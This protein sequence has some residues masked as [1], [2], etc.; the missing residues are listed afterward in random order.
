MGGMGS[1]VPHMQDLF[2]QVP[3]HL[4]GSP[5]NLMPVIHNV[6]PPSNVSKISTMYES[7]IYTKLDD[8]SGLAPSWARAVK[9]PIPESHEAQASKAKKMANSRMTVKEFLASKDMNGCK[10]RQVLDLIQEKNMQEVDHRF[11]WKPAYIDLV[12]RTVSKPR[13]RTSET[14]TVSME[15][16]VKRIPKV[17]QFT[18]G[19]LG[20]ARLHQPLGAGVVDVSGFGH[21]QGHHGIGAMYPGPRSSYG[22][23]QGQPMIEIA[24]GPRHSEHLGPQH[25]DQGYLPM[26]MPPP[27]PPPPPH[28]GPR[29]AGPPAMV[30]VMHDHHDAHGQHPMDHQ[31]MKPGK[32]YHGEPGQ[33]GGFDDHHGGHSSSLKKK[34][35]LRKIDVHNH[36]SKGKAG[37]GHKESYHDSSSDSSGLFD[38]S[39][40]ETVL[41]TPSSSISGRDYKY[42]NHR[43]SSSNKRSREHLTD[44]HRRDSRDSHHNYKTI[45]PRQ[46]RR[47]SPHPHS[48]HRESSA[49]EDEGKVVLEAAKAVREAAAALQRSTSVRTTE[50][51]HLPGHAY[52]YDERIP[53]E[54]ESRRP[55]TLGEA[56][57]RRA[58]EVHRVPDY[59]D[60]LYE[61]RLDIARDI[62][63]QEMLEREMRNLDLRDRTLHD[64]ELYDRERLRQEELADLRRD[65]A[66]YQSRSGLRFGRSSY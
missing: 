3:Q 19:S 29:N 2:G 6:N 54:H 27:P 8:G 51:P 62:R 7:F 18:N 43:R 38:Y 4:A 24:P 57:A 22:G 5:P 60:R 33:F 17:M 64:R 55:S 49:Y 25:P 12:Q 13:T 42:E 26:P 40:N 36:K 1:P 28:N 37:K 30:Q 66:G 45:Q 61:E 59:R 32:Q 44:R 14:E 35:S 20:S 39:D 53:R 23:S 9:T 34:K 56:L 31:N 16:I 15:V 21:G 50:R 52:T 41:L 65:R 47:G 58:S 10:R 63:G 11:E 48:G 46:H